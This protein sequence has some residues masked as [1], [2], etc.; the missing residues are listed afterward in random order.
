MTIR[1]WNEEV[2]V[3]VVG[4]G[5]GALVA[6]N[7]AADAGA[8]VMV[9]EK[10]SKLGGGSALS[11][12]LVFVPNHP[13]MSET[14]VSDTREDAL[15]YLRQLNR[16]F[17]SDE[18][19]E[20]FLDAARQMVVWVQEQTPLRF[21][22]VNHL[23]DFHCELEG[24][25][26]G[27]RHLAALPY[28][29]K[30]LGD[31]AELT[32][33]S[34]SLPLA[35]FEIEA[36]GGPAKIRS[37]DFQLIAERI[38]EDIRAQGAALVAPLV[39]GC[40]DRG[41]ELRVNTRVTK[42]VRDGER[43]AGVEVEQ[44]DG[45]Y[46]IRAQRG[47]ILGSGGFEWNATLNARF[48]RGP[49]AGPLTVPTNE[50]DG[51]LMGMEVGASLGLMH[52]SVWCP[53]LHIPGEEYEGRPLWRNLAS[54]KAR[55]HAILVNRH[56]HRFVNESLNYADMGHAL[57]AFDPC[58]YTWANLPAYLVF[59]SAYKSTYPV[60]TAMPGEA[61]PDW[62]AQGTTIRELAKAI[63]V[64]P[65]GLEATIQRFNRFCATG[66]DEDFYRGATAFD[67][68][69]GDPETSKPN[70]ALG[71]LDSP[72][73]YAVKIEVGSFGNRGGLLG[74]TKAQVLDARGSPIPGLYACGNTLAQ[75][76]LG[77]GYEGGGTLAQAMTFGF[78][79]GRTAVREG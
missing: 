45:N 36:M 48:L 71:A 14:G 52:E 54:E 33:R 32:R 27:G 22:P 25:K 44:T 21:R 46:R 64:D 59:D 39:K 60:G 66:V 62:I 47:V 70:P 51:H 13:W 5:A 11:T 77:F 20:A 57:L 38:A 9:L 18:I 67:R 65:K 37:W 29:A 19:L 15:R 23:P 76:A 7:V 16:G 49:L 69:F 17:A 53:V 2:D 1:S 28:D 31:W 4:S 30:Q 12:G 43:V 75:M 55:P 10:S 61:A 74:N 40:L 50:G 26:E 8:E 78:V 73:F 63:G 68:Y 72:P 56:G 41:V 58:S 79:A 34:Q 6:A 24:G 3:I 42:L 35:Y